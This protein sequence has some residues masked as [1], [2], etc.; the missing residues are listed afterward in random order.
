VTRYA[1]QL[2]QALAEHRREQALALLNRKLTEQAEM[3][4]NAG[5]DW[6]RGA[7]EASTPVNPPDSGVS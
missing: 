5:P 3:R 6:L 4:V 2:R 7:P 1:R